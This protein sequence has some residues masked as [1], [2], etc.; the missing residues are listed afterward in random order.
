MKIENP[1][2]QQFLKNYKP[3]FGNPFDLLI[4][5]SL[6]KLERKSLS[7]EDRKY[8]ESSIIY[9]FNKMKK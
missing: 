2:L 9:Y 7:K 4:Q 3:K 8:I 6:K 1:R 5:K